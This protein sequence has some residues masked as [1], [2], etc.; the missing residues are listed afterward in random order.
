MTRQEESTGMTGGEY[1][2]DRRRGTGMTERGRR[3]TGKGA[4]G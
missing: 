1:W 3:I 2:D 4:L